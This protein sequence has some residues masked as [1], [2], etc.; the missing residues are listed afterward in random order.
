MVAIT[1]IVWVEKVWRYGD[2]AAVVVGVGL[3]LLGILTAVDPQLIL[4]R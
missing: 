4:G 1:L 3:M 2:H